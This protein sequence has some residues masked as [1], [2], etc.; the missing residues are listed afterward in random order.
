MG[1]VSYTSRG[2]KS[3]VSL[4]KWKTIYYTLFSCI[5][6]QRKQASRALGPE[7]LKSVLCSVQLL[8]L[9]QVKS[10]PHASISPFSTFLLPL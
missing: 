6:I 1:Y 2:L 8:H 4:M 5:E 3:S 9:G 7:D 10:S